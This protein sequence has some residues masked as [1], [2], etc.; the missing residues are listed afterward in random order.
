M[1]LSVFMVIAL[2]YLPFDNFLIQNFGYMVRLAFEQFF[3]GA[4]AAT[5]ACSIFLSKD[6]E[7]NEVEAVKP[8][9]DPKELRL[10]DIIDKRLY[11]QRILSSGFLSVFGMFII[12]FV[13]NYLDINTAND[14]TFK[15]KLLVGVFSFM[16]GLYQSKFLSNIEK[17]FD[18]FAKSKLSGKK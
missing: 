12:L 7:I 4:L 15:Q 13:F 6:K 18:N 10:P 17:F 9:P 3:Y 11:I 5:I 8:N 2:H 16:I 1:G 14:F